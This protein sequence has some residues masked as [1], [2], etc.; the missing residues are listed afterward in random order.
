MNP[1]Q[2]VQVKQPSPCNGATRGAGCSPGTLPAVAPCTARQGSPEPQRVPPSHAPGQT[3]AVARGPRPAREARAPGPQG[4]VC[5]MAQAGAAAAYLAAHGLDVYLRD[6]A[7]CGAPGV[8]AGSAVDRRLT[9]IARGRAA[10]LPALLRPPNSSTPHTPFTPLNTQTPA[11]SRRAR[12]SAASR[13]ARRW[14]GACMH[15]AA[16]CERGGVRSLENIT[17][18]IISI[19]HDPRYAAPP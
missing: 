1:I 6:A 4:A 11:S 8:A 3:A 9:V 10:P 13:C 17:R 16:A 5:A 2:A 19:V 15:A 18:S 7:R 14:Q 12:R